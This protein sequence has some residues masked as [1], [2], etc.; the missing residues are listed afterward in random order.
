[1]ANC[2][3][4]CVSVSEYKISLTKKDFSVRVVDGIRKCHWVM[5]MWLQLHLFS[6]SSSGLVIS[7]KA[8]RKELRSLVL[9]KHNT[10]ETS[11]L[12]SGAT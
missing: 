2:G 4:V 12:I 3:F 8:C 7:I 1:M 10:V 11:V 6:L 9:V 5:L